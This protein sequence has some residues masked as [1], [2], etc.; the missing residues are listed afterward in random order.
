MGYSDTIDFQNRFHL[1]VRHLHPKRDI[2]V[3]DGCRG[4]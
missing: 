1:G 3:H 4:T 2:V